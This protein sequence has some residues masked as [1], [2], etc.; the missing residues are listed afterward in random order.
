VGLLQCPGLNASSAGAR[1]A[2]DARHPLEP[3]LL[4]AGD[5]YVFGGKEYTRADDVE[6]LQAALP[7]V[8]HVIAVPSLRAGDSAGSSK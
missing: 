8:E 6:R 4:I 1:H 5:G 3:K 2:R 7:S